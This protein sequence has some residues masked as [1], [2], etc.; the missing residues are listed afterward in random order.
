M[1]VAPKQ[2]Y[3]QTLLETFKCF[4]CM[5][6][7]QDAHLCPHCSKLCCYSCMRRWLTE[8]RSQ[9][10]HCR[11]TLHLHEIVNCRWVED[12]SEQLDCLN[13]AVDSRNIQ[14][15]LEQSC[16]SHDEPLT[17]FCISCNVTICH[18]CA[19]FDN[20]AHIGH[21]FQPIEEVYNETIVKLEE[22]C[23][24]LKSKQDLIKKDI[25]EVDKNI[26]DVHQAKELKVR[27]I[28]TAVECMM[29]DLEKDLD[30]KLSTLVSQKN[31]LVHESKQI[32]EFL[33]DCNMEISRM[34]M[35]Q[36]VSNASN[37][38]RTINIMQKKQTPILMSVNPDFH[39]V[40]TPKFEGGNLVIK[41]FSEKMFQSEPI[42]SLPIGSNGVSWRLKVYPNGNGI[43][44]DRYL[45]VFLEL[46]SGPPGV[47]RYEYR[48]EMINQLNNNDA[49]KNVLREFT[50]DFEIGEC[51]GYNRFFRLDLLENEGFLIQ[52]TLILKFSVRPPTYYQKCREQQWYLSRLELENSVLSQNFEDLKQKIPAK[53]KP[54]SNEIPSPK[55]KLKIKIQSLL[56][57]FECVEATSAN[58]C[59][60]KYF[61]SDEIVKD[62]TPS[63][64]LVHPP[65]NVQT[66]F[67]GETSN[68]FQGETAQLMFE[69]LS[70]LFQETEVP[71]RTIDIGSFR[72]K[73]IDNSENPSHP[74]LNSE[75]CSLV[76]KENNTDSSKKSSTDENVQVVNKIQSEITEARFR[77]TKLE[78]A[79]RSTHSECFSKPS[80][81][82]HLTLS[83]NDVNLQTSNEDNNLNTSSHSIKKLVELD[84]TDMLDSSEDSYIA[85]LTE[86]LD[87]ILSSVLTEDVYREWDFMESSS[88]DS[89]QSNTNEPLCPDHLGRNE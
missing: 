23:D 88:S 59:Q 32:E 14:P 61:E 42:Y 36:L 81:S 58:K 63:N 6:K 67:D 31:H 3:L 57:E 66:L 84:E 15:C 52:N 33:H 86:N 9:C 7:I 18:R 49:S 20:S 68:R 78:N 64:N 24:N 21:S 51:W 22:N 10:P 48:I 85:N 87:G 19:L 46:T 40:V 53:V 43:V 82:N 16:Q 8:Q 62:L 72:E 73:L 44:R 74:D 2:E 65:I 41:S 28:R 55:K 37:F 70:R 29:I 45:S 11:A 30:T 76:L 35:S 17:V 77:L 5:E 47:S 4:I 56:D 69:R 38:M 83:V 25:K 60:K 39:S 1:A 80:S 27:E 89:E 34:T 71:D 75:N 79:M 26:K 13:N 12:V 54:I 50:S